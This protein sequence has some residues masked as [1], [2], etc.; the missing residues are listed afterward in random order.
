MSSRTSEL[1]VLEQAG[2]PQG[3]PLS[4]ILVLFFNA[5]LVQAQR[6]SSITIGQ[7]ASVQEFQVTHVKDRRERLSCTRE[8][9]R[10]NSTLY[11]CSVGC[12]TQC[13]RQRGQR[14]ASS[15]TSSIGKRHSQYYQHVGQKPD[16]WH[17]RRYGGWRP[18]KR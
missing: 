5:D 6:P 15:R 10:S 2:L 12:E 14:R 18:D 7:A 16:S 9:A 3:S 17:P 13:D 8:G 4:L 11:F 1:S